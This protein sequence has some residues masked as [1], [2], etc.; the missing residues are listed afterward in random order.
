ML[1]SVNDKLTREQISTLEIEAGSLLLDAIKRYYPA[2]QDRVSAPVTVLVNNDIII[3]TCWANWR[4]KASDSVTFLREPKGGFVPFIIKLVATT[5]INYLVSKAFAPKQDNYQ[6]SATGESVYQSGRSS[7]SPRLGSPPAELFGVFQNVPDLISAPYLYYSGNVQ[8]RCL[9]LGCGVG[10]Y[11]F[12][13]IKI[14]D[15][16]ITRLT[17]I[18]YTVFNPGEDVTGHIAHKHIYTSLEVGGTSASEGLELESGGYE[19]ADNE[20]PAGLEYDFSGNTI[21]AVEQVDDGLGGY[22]ATP[23]SWPYLVGNFIKIISD[24]NSG[25]YKV[26]AVSSDVITLTDDVG[27]PITFSGTAAIDAEI[28]EVLAIAEGDWIG[29][30]LGCPEGV[31]T[32][33]GEVDLLY[34]GGVGREDSKGNIQ[35]ITITTEIEWREYG[36]ETWT[37]QAVTK[38]AA[39]RDDQAD[40]IPVDYGSA[41][42]PEIRMRRTSAS[43]DSQ[44]IDRKSVV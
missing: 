26:S 22:T 10:E 43:S 37:S 1:I 39:T 8:Y 12:L 38:T 36:T 15:T 42:T 6:T 16:D 31:T 29:P 23:Y 32:T 21:T 3:Q 28:D 35:S 13:K 41:I 14:A 7:N 19:S 34:R 17:G 20:M 4:I 25:V 11:D 9:L 2:Y 27:E 40:T 18:D 30:F 44:T 5:A 33:N 24:F